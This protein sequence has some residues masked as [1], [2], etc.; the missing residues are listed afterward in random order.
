MQQLV[1]RGVHLHWVYSGGV[2]AY[3]NHADQFFDCFRSVRFEGRV[4]QQYFADANHTF[5]ERQSQAQLVAAVV[6]WATRTF[7]PPAG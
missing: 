1:D 4:T 3:Y 5:T 6:A 7:P 2:D